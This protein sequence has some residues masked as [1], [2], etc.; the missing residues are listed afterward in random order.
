MEHYTRHVVY[1]HEWNGVIIIYDNRTTI[2]SATWF[3]SDV[4]IR[5]MWRT[6]VSGNAGPE[7]AGERKKLDCGLSLTTVSQ[8][9]QHAYSI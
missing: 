4:L 1:H 2:H 7:Y 8:L 3:D 5:V 9:P 6:T